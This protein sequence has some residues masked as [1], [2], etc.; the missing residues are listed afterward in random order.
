MA[1]RRRSDSPN[2]RRSL[3]LGPRAPGH[4]FRTRASSRSL[5]PPLRDRKFADSSL[6]GTG[7]ELPVR[8]CDGWVGI[9]KSDLAVVGPSLALLER[10]H[11]HCCDPCSKWYLGKGTLAD[12]VA[13]HERKITPGVIPFGGTLLQGC[14][15]PGAAFGPE[16][17]S[18]GKQL[19]R[20]SLDPPFARPQW[21]QKLFYSLAGFEPR[22][23]GLE[24]LLPA[25]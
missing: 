20:D 3:L 23:E 4:F 10:F 8:R 5:R 2:I 6:E 25:D 11:R 1:Q 22:G 17:P 24:F 13:R 15:H 18:C 7:F 19:G 16:I 12:Q 21:L 14:C 9:C